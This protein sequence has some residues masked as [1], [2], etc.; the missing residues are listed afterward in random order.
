MK[1]KPVKKP[2]RKV[3]IKILSDQAPLTEVEYAFPLPRLLGVFLVSLLDFLQKTSWG[4]PVENSP[5]TTSTVQH[6]FA[7]GIKSARVVDMRSLDTE[8][9]YE[10]GHNEPFQD[11]MHRVEY[12]AGKGGEIKFIADYNESQ[13][14]I[15]VGEP[16][17]YD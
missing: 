3:L 7:D 17:Q 9:I 12:Y 15:I 13:L 6:E 1:R 8:V 4:I 16:Q 5:F 2:A 10:R 14:M 11:F